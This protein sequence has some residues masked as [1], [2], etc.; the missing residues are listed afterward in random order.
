MCGRGET[1][2]T[3]HVAGRSGYLS[4]GE[5]G[6]RVLDHREKEES[7]LGGYVRAEVET[8]CRAG[9][10]S[11]HCTAAGV[12]EAQDCGRGGVQVH[13]DDRVV[14][15]RYPHGNPRERLRGGSRDRLG[16]LSGG[17]V[18]T[19]EVTAPVRCQH[20]CLGDRPTARDGHGVIDVRAGRCC[21]ATRSEGE[22]GDQEGTEEGSRGCFHIH[23]RWSSQLGTSN[24]GI[25]L[26]RQ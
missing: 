10:C 5:R 15:E 17:E 14:H 26:R 1:E 4:E 2:H 8:Q 19:L 18:D 13:R 22:A 21:G 7:L 24:D 6:G 11:G 12:Q 23:P 25:T 9:F 3:K 16:D 20:G